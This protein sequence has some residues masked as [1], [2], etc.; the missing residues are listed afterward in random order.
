VLDFD[1]VDDTTRVRRRV[2]NPGRLLDDAADDGRIVLELADR[3]LRLP[4]H[5][6]PALQLLLSTEHVEVAALPGLDRDGRAV[7]TRRLVKEGLLEI[8]G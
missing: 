2:D 4:P 6:A 8:V 5:T 3:R 1:A 7:L